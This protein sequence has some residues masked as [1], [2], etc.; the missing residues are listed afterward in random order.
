MTNAVKRSAR[1]CARQDRNT[2]RV[3]GGT[4]P[5]LLHVG[6]YRLTYLVHQLRRTAISI[7]R[8]RSLGFTSGVGRQLLNAASPCCHCVQRELDS[9]LV[10]SHVFEHIIEFWD[11]KRV[12]P[13]L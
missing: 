2:L 10:L 1:L 3:G 4:G 7:R 9:L 13:Q 5:Y 11:P 6:S 12:C 8:D